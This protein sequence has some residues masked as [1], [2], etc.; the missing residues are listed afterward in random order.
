MEDKRDN[1]FGWDRPRRALDAL[2]DRS[3]GIK[4]ENITKK[5]SD[6]VRAYI[7]WLESKALMLKEIRPEL[8][9][10]SY[11]EQLYK[12]RYPINVRR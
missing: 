9:E 6:E 10:G 1:V 4:G 12:M 7:L 8:I 11:E 2:I 5:R 3:L